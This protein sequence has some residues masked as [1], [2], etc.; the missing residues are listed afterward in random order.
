MRKS[1]KTG[2]T[3]T[4]REYQ[5]KSKGKKLYLSQP[6]SYSQNKTNNSKRMP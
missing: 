5:S 6:Y 3:N 2:T 4:I 1:Q